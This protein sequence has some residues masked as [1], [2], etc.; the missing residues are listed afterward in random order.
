MAV[1]R[2]EFLQSAGWGGATLAAPRC[3]ASAS[4]LPN[5]LVILADDLGY[6]DPGCYNR[7]SRIPTPAI[8]GLASQG[9]RFTDAH[10]PTSLCTPTRYGLLTGRYCWRTSLKSGVLNGYS[11][12]LIEPGRMTVASLLK[13]KGYRTGCIG[14]WHLG[15]GGGEKTDYDGIL[16]PGPL[17]A[18]FDYFFGIPA[19]L[20]M[21]P[22][23]YV[24]N[25][26]AVEKP[27][28]TVADSNEF[29]GAFW[30][31]GPIAP[32]FRHDDVLPALT[33]KSVDFI[34]GHAR[35][36]S[37]NPFFLY[38]ALTS[39]HTPWLPT[40]P[41]RGRSK[42]GKYGDFVAMTD[43]AVARVLRA[44]EETKQERDTLV[45]FASDN[46]AYWTSEEIVA[47][48]HR[49]N[50]SWRG[51]KSDIWEGGHR[52]PFIARWPGKIRSGG[53]SVEIACLT[54][55]LATIA[56]IAGTSLPNNAAEDSFSLLPA[57][58]GRKLDKP[59]R[60][61]I[62]HHSGSG[63][64]SI[65][66]GEWKLHLGRGSGGFTDPREYKPKP[67][68]PEGE[69]FNLARGPSE[70]VNLY[71]LYPDIVKSL[72]EL[73]EKYRRQGFSRPMPG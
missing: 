52:V 14:K 46:G 36:R 11:P 53:V 2:R 44:L 21:P 54:D 10:A 68:E 41:F 67:G 5:V 28:G 37:G 70:S 40:E 34:R 18:G 43:D 45:I 26:H 20:D 51:Q 42:A 71:L 13:Q 12:S 24:E 69:L 49:A 1:N 30:R 50:A 39:P 9:I 19:S 32:G 27:T 56:D 4:E 47:F 63:Q 35:S 60:E 7:E 3:F 59:I 72:T 66:K 8:D 57:F 38:V 55:V 61:A 25:D 15:L 33:A 62:V 22:Y 58:L 64:F 23:L 6:G 29:R 31:G 16:R 17:E 65:R 48:G 73:L